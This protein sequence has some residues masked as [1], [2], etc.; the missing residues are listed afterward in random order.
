MPDDTANRKQRVGQD[1]LCSPGSDKRCGLHHALWNAS[2]WLVQYVGFPSRTNVKTCRAINLFLNLLGK[3]S[4]K[5]WVSGNSFTQSLSLCVWKQN[6]TAG[7]S[8]IFKLPLHVFVEVPNLFAVTC[9][10][11]TLEATDMDGGHPAFHLWLR[12]KPAASPLTSQTF[13]SCPLPV[14]AWW[15]ALPTLRSLVALTI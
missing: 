1:F 13:L 4:G 14:A 11:Q 6:G 9:G 15:L 12:G 2:G 8:S 3:S 10:G 5:T 7:G